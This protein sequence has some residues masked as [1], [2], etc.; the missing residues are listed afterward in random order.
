MVLLTRRVSV[1]MVQKSA[2]AGA[3][4]VAA[5]SAPTVLAL[6]TAVRSGITL[7]AVGRTDGFEVFTHPHRVAGLAQAVLAESEGLK[8]GEQPLNGVEI[9]RIGQGCVLVNGS[10][11]GSRQDGDRSFSL[12]VGLQARAGRASRS[13]C[14]R[15]VGMPCFPCI[16]ATNWVA[17]AVSPPAAVT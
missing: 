9:G 6:T 12:I 17:F 8:L 5:I 14:C 11:A 13:T 16:P 3:P 4:I 15:K 1:E 2:V 7:I 10:G